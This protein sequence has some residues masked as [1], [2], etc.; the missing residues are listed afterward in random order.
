[1][2]KFITLFLLI[3]LSIN[4]LNNSSAFAD[5]GSNDQQTLSKDPPIE[6]TVFEE[7]QGILVSHG[8]SYQALNKEKENNEKSYTIKQMGKQQEHTLYEVVDGGDLPYNMVLDVHGDQSVFQAVGEIAINS[9]NI[10]EVKND[11]RLSTEIKSDLDKLLQEI[12]ERNLKDVSVT[13]YSPNLLVSDTSADEV[14][15][16]AP[17]HS[18]TSPTYWWGEG[19]HRYKLE[20]LMIRNYVSNTGDKYFNSKLE[21][22][23]FWN[24]VFSN[25]VKTLVNN[26]TGLWEVTDIPAQIS[27]IIPFPSQIGGTTGD[28]IRAYITEDKNINYYSIQYPQADYTTKAI[29][30]ESWHRLVGITIV[31]G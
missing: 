10:D 15:V 29:G 25:T 9:N 30:E 23:D 7:H 6:L 27:G 16:M 11:N 13:L 20:T 28:R 17:G 8:S 19:G 2:R 5:D 3:V 14:S 22:R 18:W 12:K 26:V 4:F 24:K 31:N 1:M 21:A